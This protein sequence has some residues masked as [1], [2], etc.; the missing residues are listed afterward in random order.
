MERKISNKLCFII[1]LSLTL[2]ITVFSVIYIILDSPAILGSETVSI[3]MGNEVNTETISL[4]NATIYDL[5]RLPQID[6]SMAERIIAYRD[7]NGKFNSLA[8][9]K[10]IKGIGD[11]TYERL[12]PFITL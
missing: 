2:L 1:L 7:E 10:N 6:E 5:I 3:V 11:K 9:L 8:E 12:L 4:N